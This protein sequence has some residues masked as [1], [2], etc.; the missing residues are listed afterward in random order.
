MYDTTFDELRDLEEGWHF[1]SGKPVVDELLDSAESVH[2]A[3]GDLDNESFEI[4]PF[5]TGGLQIN[6]YGENE[7]SVVV[8]YRPDDGIVVFYYEDMDDIGSEKKSQDISE[9]E[10]INFISNELSTLI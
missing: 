3:L 5:P 7:D 9:Q 8:E 4:F 2:E 1:G 10:A 6:Y